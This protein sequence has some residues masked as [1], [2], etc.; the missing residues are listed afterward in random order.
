MPHQP[1]IS[2]PPGLAQG[3]GAAYLPFRPDD[4]VTMPARNQAAFDFASAVRARRSS[5]LAPCPRATS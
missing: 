5:S 1:S 4:G 2:Q 3:D